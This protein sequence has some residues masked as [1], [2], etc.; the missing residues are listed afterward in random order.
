MEDGIN[1]MG[2]SSGSQAEKRDIKLK[3]PLLC[4]GDPL[5]WWT[6]PLVHDAGGP[7]ELLLTFH[8]P[9]ELLLTVIT[10]LLL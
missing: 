3:F 10:L 5:G 6:S 4:G 1:S 8:L 7:A 9:S 2:G